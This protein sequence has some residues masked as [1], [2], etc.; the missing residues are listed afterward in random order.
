MS[1]CHV[2]VVIYIHVCLFVFVFYVIGRI[3]ERDDI[4]IIN[5]NK[6]GAVVNMGVTDYIE[7]L[8]DN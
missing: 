8:K 1:L 6:V 7:N 3:L 2:F 5:A 4:V